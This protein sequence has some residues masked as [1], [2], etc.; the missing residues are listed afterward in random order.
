MLDHDDEQRLAEI[1]A[2]L[3]LDAPDLHR[4]FAGDDGE[5]ERPPLSTGGAAVRSVLALGAAVIVTTLATFVLGPNLGG[6]IAVVS[7]SVAGMYA[8]QILRGC[9]GV[10][11]TR[12][13]NR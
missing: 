2:H 10:R 12:R 8:Y 1:E 6:L 7:L 4:L 13:D 3:R 11:R 5:A 9:P